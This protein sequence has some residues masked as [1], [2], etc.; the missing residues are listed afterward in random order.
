VPIFTNDNKAQVMDYAGRVLQ[1][2]REKHSV[3]LDDD[4]QNS[5]GWRFAEAELRGVPVRI[6]VGPRDLAKEQL[7]LV[8]RDTGEKIIVPVREAQARVAGLLAE[9][10]NNLFHRALAFRK[11]NTHQAA[12]YESFKRI[13]EEQGGFVESPWCGSAACEA[14]IK[15]ETKATIRVL[16][17]GR[18]D[19]EGRACLLCGQQARQ[20]AVFARAY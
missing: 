16:P 11:E 14:R 8:R 13:V 15:D 1:S 2:L 9:I 4:E 5:P 17:L 10:Q 7:V 3:E 6:E 19:F 18:N 12:D 20:L